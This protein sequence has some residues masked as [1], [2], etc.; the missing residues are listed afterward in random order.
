MDFLTHLN[1]VEVVAVVAS[2]LCVWLYTREDVWSWPTAIV[3]AAL[4]LF[5]FFQARFYAQMILQGVY[6]VISIYGWYQWLYGGA[7]QSALKISRVTPTT[8]LV[9]T[10]IVGGGMAVIMYVLTTYTD[11]AAVPFWDALTAAMSLAAQWMLAR[12]ILENWLVWIVADVIY[13]GMFVYQGLYP[14]ALLYAGFL[15]LATHGFFAWRTS[16]RAETDTESA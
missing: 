8:A 12:K 4:Y 11:N 14:T 13:V 6:I 9:L 1:Y 10:G 2:F 16:M 7:E 15:V 3:A 5:V